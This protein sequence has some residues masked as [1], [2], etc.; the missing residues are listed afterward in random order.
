MP[1]QFVTI[2]GKRVPI[3][4]ITS[5][6]RPFPFSM[7]F[8]SEPISILE[9]DITGNNRNIQQF[10]RNIG[11]NRKPSAIKFAENSIKKL[12]AENI[13]RVKEINHRKEQAK[14]H[15]LRFGKG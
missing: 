14:I 6:E 7:D 5:R 2:R 3:S 1:K 11:M 4:D 15:K 8:H 10:E 12:Q 9:N 13:K